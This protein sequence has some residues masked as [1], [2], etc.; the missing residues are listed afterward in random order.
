MHQLL[1]IEAWTLT[2]VLT[3]KMKKEIKCTSL[4]VQTHLTKFELHAANSPSCRNNLESLEWKIHNQTE[5]LVHNIPAR[6][7]K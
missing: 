2:V 4:F 1:Y 5:Y 3:V 7:K 6:R